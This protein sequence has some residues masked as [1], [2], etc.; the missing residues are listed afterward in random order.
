MRDDLEEFFNM[1]KNADQIFWAHIF[2][3][4]LK[5]RDSHQTT[6]SFLKSIPFFQ[7]LKKA[8]L[9]E[10]AKIL[11]DRDYEK[12]EFLFEIGQPG[13]AMF[14]IKEGEI[15]IETPTSQGSYAQLA[16]LKD[17]SFLGE[18][19]L[20][21]ESPRS[22]TARAI[23][24]VKAFC[25]FRSD[26]EKLAERRPDISSEIYKILATMTGERLKKTNSLLKV[27]QTR[28]REAA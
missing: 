13:A 16:V 6:L 9:D 17:H 28:K 22:A 14:L 11:H 5:Q 12:D 27:A 23:T 19:A 25:L 18:L 4:F 3:H 26:L 10:V 7:R 1:A 8:Q 2:D 21:D 15:S 24:P 20:L